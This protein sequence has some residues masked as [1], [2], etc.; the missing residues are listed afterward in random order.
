[1]RLLFATSEITPFSRSCEIA[2]ICRAL[3]KALR[4]LDHTITVV[5]PLYR[6]V[7]PAEHS[8]ARRL[9]TIDVKVGARDFSCEI[10]DGRTAGGVDL[11][12]VGN[13]ELFSDHSP[14][15][16]A[17]AEADA[18]RAALFSHVI[19]D[20][21]RNAEPAFDIVQTYD[22]L[23][24]LSVVL[25]KQNWPQL[26][27]IL[28]LQDLERRGHFKL[29]LNDLLG[30]LPQVADTIA[31]GR[32]YD[33]LKGAIT[34][35]DT[36]AAASLSYIEEM[37]ENNRANG[38]KEVIQSNREKLIAIVNGLDAA[39]W[40][41][42][43]DVH[44]RFRFD[45]NNLEGKHRCKAAFQHAVSLP[46]RTD[47][48]L[49]ALANDL[50]PQKGGHLVK[51]VAAQILRN[52]LQLVVLCDEENETVRELQEIAE[53]YP[54][55]LVIIVSSDK[56]LIHQMIAASDFF[57]MPYECEPFG[58]LQL[59]AQRYGALPVVRKSGC[60]VETVVDCD[61]SLQTGN[62]FAFEKEE[63]NDF[64]ATI[65]RAASAFYKPKA[66][67]SLRQR[68]MKLDHSWD[69]TARHYDY[70]YKRIA[71]SK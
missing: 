34:A 25:I 59:S 69:R 5:S 19:V 53:R 55:R 32:E 44:I 68:V 39:V 60:F 58:I 47:V 40:N 48:P 14:T 66:F 22:W 26:P 9:R 46:V 18:L 3:P 36:I 63:P 67:K 51:A 45:P 7:N 37:R 64:L 41:P 57:L 11:L 56:A 33:L 2:D 1:M 15:N 70:L 12:F 50:S 10:Y 6:D 49:F 52:D 21:L 43:S 17:G 54:D 62:G 30:L 24:A 16:C 42:I 61:S 13:Q 28:S 27:V 31:L 4:G 20:I 38:L 8:L 71:S 65:Q 35:A 23:A 29:P